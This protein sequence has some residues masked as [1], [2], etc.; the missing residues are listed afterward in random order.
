MLQKS[1]SQISFIAAL[2][3]RFRGWSMALIA[4]RE[5]SNNLPRL[6]DN[7][8]DVRDSLKRNINLARF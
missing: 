2:G 5:S 4:P 1:L 3:F 7:W 6:D 8:N